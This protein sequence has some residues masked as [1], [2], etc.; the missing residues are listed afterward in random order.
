MGVDFDLDLDSIPAVPL[1]VLVAAVV[2]RR[3]VSDATLLTVFAHPPPDQ[4]VFGPVW[5]ATDGYLSSQTLVHL[6]MLAVVVGVPVWYVSGLQWN[7][8]GLRR[9]RL[10][11]GVAGIVALWLGAQAVGAVVARAGG[12]LALSPSW[13]AM[14]ATGWARALVPEF[15][16]SALEEEVFYRG[17]L[18]SQVYLVARRHLTGERRALA[19]AVVST[20]AW[21]ALAHVPARLVQG[22]PL[23]LPLDLA[24]LFLLGVVF[25]LVYLRTGNL[26]LAVGVHAL[27]NDPAPLF[28]DP[29]AARAVVLGLTLLALVAWPWIRRTDERVL[30]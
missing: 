20:Q 25:A 19:V 8:V 11:V 4:P 21:F 5:R 10:P 2:A 1:W 16:G 7:H 9:R 23:P 17:L 30:G 29:P 15:F 22:A 6:L 14:G 13:Q 27:S 12:S 24:G 28:L 26:F 3:A 18:L